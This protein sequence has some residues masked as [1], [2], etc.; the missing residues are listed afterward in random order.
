MLSS[1][2]TPDS[3]TAAGGARVG[4]NPQSVERV[5][6]GENWQIKHK[7]NG[8]VMPDTSNARNRY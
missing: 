8:F 5:V 3:L 6:V 2:K 1:E 4:G 7:R